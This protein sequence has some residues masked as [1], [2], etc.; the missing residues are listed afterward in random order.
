MSDPTRA[1]VPT[2]ELYYE[3]RSA[4]RGYGP[5]PDPDR[6]RIARRYRLHAAPDLDTAL[7]GLDFAVRPQELYLKWQSEQ[8]Q[9][10]ALAGAYVY[11]GRV[12]D[13]DT[14]NP[15][16]ALQPVCFVHRIKGLEQP[17]VPDWIAALLA[18]H[19]CF[20]GKD[21]HA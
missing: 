12:R 18:E 7:T 3:D 2:A 15:A 17:V 10:L 14:V 16:R 20:T 5:A 13:D 1:A 9:P 6:V 11:G 4:S 8:G 19:D 21:P